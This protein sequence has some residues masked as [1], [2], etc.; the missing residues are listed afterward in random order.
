[1]THPDTDT[2]L[3]S[4][5]ETL[6]ESDEQI[7][8]AHLST[9]EQCRALQQNLQGDINR[10]GRVNL[11]IEMPAPPRLPRRWRVPMA[12]SRLAAALAVGF[13]MGYVTAQLSEPVSSV[14]VQQRLIPVEVA[15]P[16]SGYIPC[17]PVDLK[18][19]RPG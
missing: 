13:L 11:H 3:K 1:M 17:Q 10:L 8:R 14:P 12:V 15:V 7:V 19:T 18:T 6:G 16:A 4:V 9:C 2:L 5:L